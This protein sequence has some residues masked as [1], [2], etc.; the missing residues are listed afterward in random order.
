MLAHCG[1]TLQDLKIKQ[2]FTTALNTDKSNNKSPGTAYHL[3]VSTMRHLVLSCSAKQFVIA[4]NSRMCL[5][6]TV[7]LVLSSSG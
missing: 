2:Q 4:V 1:F 6:I 5:E 3:L 7:L